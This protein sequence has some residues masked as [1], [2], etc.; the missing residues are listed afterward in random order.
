MDKKFTMQKTE[1]ALQR[2]N[3]KRIQKPSEKLIKENL[4]PSPLVE[5][6]NKKHCAMLRTHN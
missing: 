2:Q 3:S 1:N 6:D 5:E 4:V